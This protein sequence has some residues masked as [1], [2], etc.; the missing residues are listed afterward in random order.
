MDAVRYL[1]EKGA[2]I[3]AQDRVRERGCTALRC[4]TFV[5]TPRNTLS[6]CTDASLTHR[7][8]KLRWMLQKMMQRGLR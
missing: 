8:V 4:M 1:V 7:M 6:S 5:F 2:N 3:E